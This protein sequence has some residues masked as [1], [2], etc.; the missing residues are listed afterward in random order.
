MIYLRSIKKVLSLKFYIL[1]TLFLLPLALYAQEFECDVIVDVKN[2]EGTSFEYVKSTLEADIENYIN[3]FRWTEIEFT[4]QERITCQINIVLTSGDQDFN[5]SAETI[6]SAR[7]P[8]YNT[9]TETNTLIVGDQ[10]WQFSYPQGKSLIHDDLQFEG[11]T[12]FIDYYIYLLLGYDFD[13]FSPLGGTSYFEKS[14]NVVDLAQNEQTVG[15]TRNSNNQR[16]RF[17]LITDLLS[18]NYLPLRNAIYTYHRLGLDT[19]TQSP[20]SARQQVLTALKEIQGAKRRSTSNFLYDIFFD[21][22][23][24]EIT[25]IFI[26]ADSRIKLEAYNILRETD[27][28]HLSEYDQL[29]N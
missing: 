25:N 19:F 16:N 7:R 21:T 26:D 17:V 23:S 13:S 22:K 12:G 28:G 8:I 5:F 6:I 29:Q 15:W 24:R 1:V 18:N 4:E 3:E 27:Q 20:E 2:L 14:Q 11:L 10:A 9:T